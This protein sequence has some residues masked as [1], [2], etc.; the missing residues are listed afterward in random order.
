[1]SDNGNSFT[2][3][4]AAASER[5][6]DH[7]F[8]GQRVIADLVGEATSTALAGLAISGRRLEPSEIAVL[9]DIAALILLADPRI[10]PL[11][12]A[13]IVASYGNTLPAFAAGNVL[14]EGAMIGPWNCGAAAEFLIDAKSRLSGDQN[15]NEAEHALAD[16][17]RQVERI[18]GFGVPMRDVDERLAAFTEKIHQRG[19]ENLPHWQAFLRIAPVVRRE[20]KLEPNFGAGLGAALLDMDFSPG[21][22][23]VVAWWFQ[24]LAYLPNVMEGAEQKQP[25][26]RSFP[27]D[28]TTYVGHAPRRS[29]RAIAQ[30]Q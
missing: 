11:K 12:L 19:R 3:P 6:T 13:R 24:A 21:Q 16:L 29:P 1:M 26:L 27:A 7:W 23:A 30:D 5:R 20:R 22:I 2:I 10:W 17:V 14:L 4:T 28:A 15:G 8:C 18:P 25:G 9:D